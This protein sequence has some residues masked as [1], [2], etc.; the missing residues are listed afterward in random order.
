VTAELVPP[1]HAADVVISANADTAAGLLTGRVS[2][3]QLDRATRRRVRG[4]A[5][6]LRRLERL[7]Q[8]ATCAAPP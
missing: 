6:A 4:T 5:D 8:R 1:G 2:P 7:T 3:Q